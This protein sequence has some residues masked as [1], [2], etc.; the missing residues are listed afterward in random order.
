MEVGTIIMLGF[1]AALAVVA[2][3]LV[4]K[5]IKLAAEEERKKGKQD[6]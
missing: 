5:S 4:S 6:E 2:C 1:I 3:I